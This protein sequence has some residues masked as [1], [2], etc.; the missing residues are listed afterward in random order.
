MATTTLNLY[1][2]LASLDA[3]T[4]HQATVTL[5]RT[6]AE[7]QVA[8]EKALDT[9]TNQLA[10]S[11][12]TLDQ[13]CASDV[14]YAVRR[15]LRGLPSSRQ[16]ARQGFSLALTELLSVMECITTKLVLDLLCQYTERTSAMSGEETR[17]MLFGRLFGIMAIVASGLLSR[18]ATT[19]TDDVLRMVNL[20]SDISNTKAYLNEVSY[21]VIINML[22][23]VDKMEDKDKVMDTILGLFVRENMAN[24]DEVNL[25]LAIQQQMAG[26][27]L[28]R[29]FKGWANDNVFDRANL[30]HMATI[31][32]E[33]PVGNNESQVDWTPQLHSV[34]DRLFSQLLTNNNN[35]N[36]SFHEF[37]T[38]VVDGNLFHQQASHGRKYWGFQVVNKVL[39]QLSTDQ[40][41]LIFTENFMRTFINNLSSSVRF[42]NKAARQ[43]ATTIQQVAEQNKQVGFAVVSQLIGKYGD[44]QFDRI[45][46]TKTVENLLATMD[47]QGIHQYLTYL[48]RLFCVQSGEERTV[49]MQREWALNQMLLLVTNPKTPKEESW[50]NAVIQFILVHTFYNVKPSSNNKKSSKKSSKSSA[51]TTDYLATF[52]EPPTPA[53]TET[54]RQ[55]CKTKF[56]SLVLALSK[57]APTKKAETGHLKTRRW[58]GFTNDG[59]LWADVIYEHYQ[60][61]GKK[62]NLVLI[63]STTDDDDDDQKA[64]L[65]KVKVS[66]LKVINEL[67]TLV[68]QEDDA[69]YHV[70]YGFEILFFHVLLHSL[71]DKEEG[72]GLLGD[73]L[74]CYDKLQEQQQQQQQQIKSNKKKTNNKKSEETDGEPEPI[75]V[76]VDILLSFLTSASPMLKGITEHVFELFSPLVTKQVMENLINIIT[77]NENNAGG[78]ELFGDDDNEDDEMDDDDVEQLDGDDDEEDDDEEDDDD[79]DDVMEIDQEDGTVDEELRQKIEEAM[80]AQG[81]LGGDSDEEELLGDDAMEAFDEKLAEIFKQKKI[82]KQNKKTM[83]ESVVHFKNNVMDFL[84]IFA[85]KNPTSPL[86]L[87]TIVPLLEI[88]QSTKAKASTVQFVNKV[89]AYLKNKLG[90]ATEVPA[91]G[92]YDD[93][94]L[95]NIVSSVHTFAIQTHGGGKARSDMSSQ[96]LLFLRKCIVGTGADVTIA[97][98]DKPA[99]QLLANY[100]TCYRDSLTLFITRKSNQ[101]HTSYFTAIIQRFPLTCWESLLDTLVTHLDPTSCANTFRHSFTCQW[102]GVLIQQCVGKKNKSVDDEFINK[103]LPRMIQGIEKSAQALLNVDDIKSGNTECMK[104]L[105]KLAALLDRTNLRLGSK[106]TTWNTSLFTDISNDKTYCT[107]LVRTTCKSILDRS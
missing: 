104:S 74:N 100:M 99:G 6:L 35:K 16:G 27:D 78:D 48:A 1:W 17:D 71:V 21:H 3:T 11:E 106:I 51:T 67:K 96:L 98:L 58:N 30:Q 38:I 41:P 8:H 90:K 88:V 76:I 105:M 93:S 31:V 85:R 61:L 70:A 39:P 64:N 32:R 42:L 107:P 4:R 37:W 28:S 95:L 25:T 12:E 29:P 26:V 87:G 20:V 15:L 94:A 23:S 22:P 63:H 40:M 7:F 53:L 52:V 36:A 66:T 80:R 84:N 91:Y 18:P 9:T 69:N 83:Q 73:L 24:V 65:T 5:I 56:Q 2:D 101:L 47:S 102:S 14:S 62:S 81:I 59:R 77:T 72:A 54:S 10:D 44:R 50:I 68:K 60:Q 33:V 19:S 55:L 34:W 46:R 49:E 103:V 79:D 43:T 45:T 13:L 75:E 97:S 86:I 57:M 82:E 92:T 89:E